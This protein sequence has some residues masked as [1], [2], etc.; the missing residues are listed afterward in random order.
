MAWRGW[1]STSVLA[2][3]ALVLSGCEVDP[4]ESAV[5]TPAHRAALNAAA[6]AVPS[7][8]PVQDGQVLTVHQID[9]GYVGSGDLTDIDSFRP[10]RWSTCAG[11]SCPEPPGTNVQLTQCARSG[12]STVCEDRVDGAL[13]GRVT[14]YND[15]RMM[16]EVLSA[17]SGMEQGQII[18]SVWYQNA[19]QRR[20]AEQQF[21]RM[22][23]TFETTFEE[24]Y[25]R[26]SD[27][28]NAL[29]DT[30]AA[31]GGAGMATTAGSAAG[32]AVPNRQVTVQDN[33]NIGNHPIEEQSR[34]KAREYGCEGAQRIPQGI[35][36]GAC[37]AFRA[38]IIIE[39]CRL[40]TPIPPAAYN[41]DQ[42]EFFRVAEALSNEG[43]NLAQICPY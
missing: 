8:P 11:A 16:L 6:G 34:Q 25:A 15:Q 30:A 26:V 7:G 37:E 31:I 41:Q 1:I 13:Q 39:A 43:A 29:F 4:L 20:R 3:A 27:E 36:G 10:L 2:G 19:E 17:E 14:I 35:S 12:S 21:G 23:T 18:S 33:Y 28:R 24:T 32:G 38:L 42:P 5:Q 40:E 9:G 22:M